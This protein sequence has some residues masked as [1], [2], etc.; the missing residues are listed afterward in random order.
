MGIIDDFFGDDRTSEQKGIDRANKDGA[1]EARDSSETDR[2]IHGVFDAMTCM[3]PG[4]R[5]HEAREAGYHNVTRNTSSKSRSSRSSGYRGGGGSGGGSSGSN[6][7][8]NST[9]QGVVIAGS[10]LGICFAS[11]ALESIMQGKSRGSSNVDYVNP[12]EPTQE[13]VLDGEVTNNEYLNYEEAR[14]LRNL[15][16]SG[17]RIIERGSPQKITDNFKGLTNLSAEQELEIVRFAKSS[18]R[19]RVKFIQSKKEMLEGLIKSIDLDFFK[20]QDG[21]KDPQYR[22]RLISEHASF[23]K[24]KQDLLELVLRSQ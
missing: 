18:S 9:I 21:V 4:T 10:F 8:N 14:L 15:E 20:M 12:S 23:L 11:I 3:V 24:N 19:Y 2:A 22:Q 5:E 13:Y 16:N 7:N 17:K 1:R 6:S